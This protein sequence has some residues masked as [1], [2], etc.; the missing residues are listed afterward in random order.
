M[1]STSVSKGMFLGIMFSVH[2]K[3]WYIKEM[4]ISGQIRVFAII[5][6]QIVSK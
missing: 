2:I 5:T 6:T 1:N 3:D 4:R